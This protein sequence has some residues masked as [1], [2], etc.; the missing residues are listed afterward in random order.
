ME[1]G[2]S[3]LPTWLAVAATGGRCDDD[4]GHVTGSRAEG[5]AC[6]GVLLEGVAGPQ[7]VGRRYELV[8]Q[9]ATTTG[10]G[11]CVADVGEHDAFYVEVVPG[12]HAVPSVHARRIR[13]DTRHRTDRRDLVPRVQNG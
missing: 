3:E 1:R 7:Q 12:T 4:E 2:G 13:N 8:V 11:R 5:D 6:G 9:S 10:D